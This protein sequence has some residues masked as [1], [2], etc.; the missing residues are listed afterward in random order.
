MLMTTLELYD[1]FDRLGTPKNGRLLVEK[2]R[3]EAP[4]RQVQSHLGNVITVYSSRKMGRSLSAESRTVEYPAMVRYEHDP[5]VLE[6]F[7]QPVKLDL[8]LTKEHSEQKYRVPHTPD[9][10]LIK[11][12][13]IVLEEWREEGRLHNLSA[14]SPRRYVREADGWRSPE[15][16]TI[17]AEMGI[18]YRLRSADEHPR[19]YVQNLVF[20][21]DYLD[22][23]CLPVEEQALAAL[24]SCFTDQAAIPLLHLLE[25]GRQDQEASRQASQSFGLADEAI[26]FGFTSDDVFKAI[27]D[28]LLAFDLSND[29]L[30][31]TD[32]VWV[33]R[34]QAAL[35]FHRR[36]EDAVRQES[37]TPWGS[38][39]TSICLGTELEY[40]GQAYRV[41]LLGQETVLLEGGDSKHEVD[42]DLLTQL[43]SQ[44]KV[45]IKA[46]DADR[47]SPADALN[48]L[49][50]KEIE[51]ALQRAEWLELA[52]IA[53]TQVPRSTRTLRRYRKAL[54]EAGDGAVDQHLALA[55]N[56]ANCG[57]RTRQ[58]PCEVL[59]AIAT[60]AKE[61]F[62]QPRNPTK[63]S[64]FRQFLDACAKAGIRACSLRTFSKELEGRRSV[65]AQKGKRW[66]YQ[67]DPIVWYLHLQESVH[68]VRPFQY[69]HIDHTELDIL[70]GSSMERKSLGK[71]W[72]SLAIDAES[73]AVVG[74]YLSFEPPS[75]K[76][77][78]MVVRDIVRRHGRMP[79]TLVLDNGKEFHSRALTR[80]C[81][82]YGCSIR[83]RP[84]ARSRSGSVME[85]HFGVVNTQ[86]IHNLEGNTQLMKH[87]RLVTKTVSPGNFVTWTLPMLHG[88]LAFFCTRIYGAEVHPAHGETPDDHLIRRMVETG[89]RRNRLVKLDDTF[90]IETCPSPTDSDTRK[91]DPARGIKV[92]HIWFWNDMFRRPDLKGQSVEVRVD[93][94]DPRHV[95]VL[96]RGQWYLCISKLRGILRD[97]T[98]VEMRY[99]FEELA[100]K[101]NIRKKDLSPERIA[102]WVNLLDA[103]AFSPV[104]AEQQAQAKDV[105]ARLGMTHAIC[106]G[107][108]TP[109]A[110]RPPGTPESMPL[111]PRPKV[112]RTPT[113]G[114][115]P[116]PEPL[117]AFSNSLPS[118]TSPSTTET[119]DPDEYTFF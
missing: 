22:P 54:R 116:R 37:G 38:R 9:F 10:L 32:R 108:A 102:E 44:G 99:A 3:K 109:V 106:L 77:C 72:L 66:A 52:Q 2:A 86:F 64:A 115:A 14:K 25:R 49:S 42:L 85:R 1:L 33:F 51:S 57:N 46:S 59:E 98:L 89:E 78:M 60:V 17:L 47:P 82:L 69:V 93:P 11:Q 97:R 61:F 103:Q 40:E 95:F 19:Q 110:E 29:D 73:R 39:A 28:D 30:S 119:E 8:W 107:E 88:A 96:I 92:G 35:Q 7:A 43:H 83:Y 45:I 41:A 94:W 5:K 105:Y 15:V 71:P 117:D 75:Y 111:P 23:A 91:V 21:A 81:Q 6:Y 101:H 76:S 50:P 100:K 90:R 113:L 112:A 87:A 36:M 63:A 26:R 58:I 27:A 62:N 70:L 74:F 56:Y 20:L 79:E 48:T 65:R 114:M 31:N 104:L 4:V 118:L 84:P 53:P 34:D 13:G 12:D 80:V 55:N 24:L 68:G 18:E 67:T 16:E